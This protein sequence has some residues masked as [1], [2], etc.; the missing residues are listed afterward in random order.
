MPKPAPELEREFERKLEIVRRF[1]DLH[2]TLTLATVDPD[3]SPRSTPLFYRSTPALSLYW[4]SSPRS[5]HSVNCAR[6]PITSIAVYAHTTF[7]RQIQGLQMRGSVSRVKDPR[8]RGIIAA[9][10]T[11]RFHLGPAPRLALRAA[12]LFCFVPSWLRYL[13]NSRRF[14]FRFELKMP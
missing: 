12:A 13:D 10:F 14:G 11:A 2:S 5:A 8:L 7:W 4:F 6:N 3:A 1:L 9:D